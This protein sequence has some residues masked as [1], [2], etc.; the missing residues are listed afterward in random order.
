MA[1]IVLIVVLNENNK[2]YL[3]IYNVK[4]IDNGFE[5]RIISKYN[6]NFNKRKLFVMFS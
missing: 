4:S 1:I 3:I 6:S 2:T 5:Q